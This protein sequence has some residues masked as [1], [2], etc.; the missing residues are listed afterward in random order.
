MSYHTVMPILFNY[1]GSQQGRP[2]PAQPKADVRADLLIHVITLAVKE[3]YL[4]P[5]I[6]VQ[7]YM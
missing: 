7:S 5:G 3:S 4:I 6:R 2:C 1:L